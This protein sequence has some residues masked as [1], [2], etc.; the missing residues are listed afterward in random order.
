MKNALAQTKTDKIKNEV[1]FRSA[2]FIF[3]AQTN[4]EFLPSIDEHCLQE[5][6]RK[7][8]RFRILNTNHMDAWL[9]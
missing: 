6:P 9:K 1:I 2:S 5:N 7:P 8:M 4:L 3:N